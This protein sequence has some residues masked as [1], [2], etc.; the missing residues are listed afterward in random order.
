MGVFD[1][2]EN[3][4]SRTRNVSKP[5]SVDSPFDL[6]TPEGAFL[7][8]VHT[9]GFSMY[10]ISY[11][12]KEE[13]LLSDDEQASLNEENLED[14]ENSLNISSSRYDSLPDSEKEK[15][16]KR[17]SY[18]ELHDALVTT[19]NQ[20]INAVAG[21]GKALVN[22]T[23]VLS[24]NGFV[25]IESL[26]VGDKMF[27]T[28]GK[29]HAVEGVFPQGE[30]KVNRVRFSNGT[31]ISC[32]SEHL[33]S[34]YI[35]S[36]EELMTKNTT[37][38]SDLLKS[39]VSLRLPYVQPERVS[40]E[41]GASCKRRPSS[42]VIKN[43]EEDLKIYTSRDLYSPSDKMETTF[44][45]PYLLGYAVSWRD[46][47]D[48]TWMNNTK[49]VFDSY[50]EIYGDD[51]HT[52]SR[53][54]DLYAKIAK[55]HQPLKLLEDCYGSDCN[56]QFLWGLIDAEMHF[57]VYKYENHYILD[58]VE[59]DKEF[60][61][62]I[63]GICDSISVNYTIEHYDNAQ[64]Y[65][66]GLHIYP[67][68]DSGFLHSRRSHGVDFEEHIFLRNSVESSK[69]LTEVE[70]TDEVAEMTCISIDSEDKLYITEGYIPTHNTTAITLKILHD[71]VTGEA[72]TLK[73]I[74]NG[75]TVRMV[76][77]MWFC[78]FLRS[79][80]AEL[81]SSVSGWQRRL[82]YSQTSNQITFSTLDAEFKRCLNAMGCETPIG[83]DS[84]L[85]GALCKAVDSCNITRDGNPLSKEDYNIISGI[86]TYYRGRLDETKY[87]HPSC[88]DYGLTPRILDLVVKQFA[89]LRQAKG[90]MDFEEIMELLYKFLYVEPNPAVQNFVADRYNF[91]YIDEFQDTSQMAYAILK[92]Y[93]RGKLWLNRFGGIVKT[94]SQGGDVP[95]GLYTASETVGKITVVGDVAQCIYG[96]RG[97][98]Y[99]I[100][101]EYFDHD[102]RPVVSTLSVNWRCPS[103]ILNPV[104]P[105]IHM[106][107]D[108]A[109]QEIIAAREGGDFTAYSFTNY[110]A[111]TRQL[112]VD[113]EKDL[114]E[115]MS[116][117]IL[118]RT[119]FD[120]MIPAFILEST[121]KI[122][123]GISGENMTLSSPLPR[124]IIGVSA[125]FT[126]RSTPSVK[127][128]LEF[129]VNYREKWSVKVLMDTLKLNNKSI[130]QIPLKDI[131]YSCP[132]ILNFVKMVRSI[133]MPD[134]T[135]RERDKDI[136][137]LRVV[138]MYMITDVFCA[139]TA[140]AESARAYIETLLYL[141]DEY[142]FKSVYEF[143][144]EVEFLNDKLHGRI[145]KSKAKVQIAT[146][147]EFKGKERDSVYVWNDSEKTF[148]SN[149]CDVDN[150]EQLNEER[151]VHYIACTRARKREHIYTITSRVGM[152]VKEMDL[153]L[154]SPPVQGV[155]LPKG[156]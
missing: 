100:L 41:L 128:A 29:L 99:R 85:Y 45:E 123:F 17:V 81:E 28:D 36:S 130:W 32:C 59:S 152:F 93:A 121:K 110:K 9:C 16:T 71:I 147:H 44:I 103:N 22:G 80:V 39:G 42:F 131:E 63:A 13:F 136:E 40:D 83:D 91:I 73:G 21:S 35:D 95:D 137:G 111:M 53:I 2:I 68:E 56:K 18:T 102:F 141:I 6:T 4:S 47:S 57:P 64:E 33:W 88:A 79:G 149:K 129:F 118:C 5:Q 143:L 10:K 51:K 106:N 90:I 1:R 65:D 104:V 127:A 145:K 19:G 27:G 98:D 67:S 112:L 150:E 124:K 108:S 86:V 48:F 58:F 120:G 122:D 101:G 148:P 11:E 43:G 72:M 52:K 113:L 133:I 94:V 25:S 3:Y 8:A 109:R 23:K 114:D 74:P 20:V 7:N 154:E 156:E 31:V 117:A 92:F 70:E 84:A 105:S 96:F 116:V 115:N 134:G 61:D 60:V 119:N 76:N 138:Y 50:K 14:Y 146:V 62:W 26:K 87:Q 153:I 151:R 132:A 77:K 107:R 66:I 144:E 75:E 55:V 155:S 49:D 125:L 38:V 135:N 69:Y 15:Y 89:N 30:K 139:D 142:D 24:S 140:Y 37:E 12:L 82:G 54:N 34:F 78:T 126:E 46:V 97:S